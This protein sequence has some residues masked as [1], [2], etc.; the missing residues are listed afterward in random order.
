MHWCTASGKEFKFSAGLVTACSSYDH[1]HQQGNNSS[2]DPRCCAHKHGVQI[3]YEA[4]KKA[5]KLALGDDLQSQAA[6]FAKL[7]NYADATR[8]ADPEAIAI[9]TTEKHDG[10]RRFHRF[11]ACPGVSRSVFE[12]CRFFPAMD[13]TFT[14]EIFSLT[15]LLAVSV[16]ADN[17]AVMI[18]W[19]L[20]EGESES[21]WRWFLSSP[22]CNSEYQ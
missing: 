12:H 11:F 6:Q 2:N 18:S 13:G 9:L 3:G 19:A 20:V 21:S 8:I 10:I 15:V 1:H 16:D 5:K 4:A 14:K 7:P 22:R 17:H